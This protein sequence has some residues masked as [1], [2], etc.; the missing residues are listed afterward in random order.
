MCTMSR[1]LYGTLE[2]VTLFKPDLDRGTDFDLK[3]VLLML[4][5]CEECAEV[6]ACCYDCVC[7]RCAVMQGYIAYF[8][9]D[10]LPGPRDNAV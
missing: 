7:Y 1:S 4:N 8:D 10:G 9:D 5:V 6:V 2:P 3:R